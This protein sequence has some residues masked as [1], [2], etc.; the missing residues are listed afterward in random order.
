MAVTPAE[1]RTLGGLAFT[2]RDISADPEFPQHVTVEVG[3][4]LSAFDTRNEANLYMLGLARE[5]AGGKRAEDSS[6]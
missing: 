1:V 2:V 4:L 6:L 5:V 3:G